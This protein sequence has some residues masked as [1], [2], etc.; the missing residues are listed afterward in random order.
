MKK[1]LVTGGA[2]YI[3]SHTV[4]SLKDKGFYPV[5]VDDLRS[6]SSF[7][8]EGLSTM[9]KDGYAFHCEDVCNV[10]SMTKIFREHRFDAVIHF[11]AY[12]SVGES[13]EEPLKYYQNN[14]QGLTNILRL[15]EEFGVPKFV[16]SSSC[17]VYG[18]PEDKQVYEHTPKRLPESPYGFT[19]WMG[20]Q[21]IEDVHRNVVPFQTLCLR[22][23]NP[24]GAHPSGM[25]G[26]L[27]K[28]IPNNLLPYITQT[29]TG[30]LPSLTVFGD[31]YPT[32]DGTC[33][34][35][36]IH[37]CDV[38][39]AHVKALLFSTS[40]PLSFFN[41]GTGYGTS[42]L[43]M[44]RLFERV[45]GKTL[46][47]SFG[48]RRKGDVVEIFANVTAA[49]SQLGWKAKRTIEEAIRDAWN[50]EQRRNKTHD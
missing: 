2:G 50:W 15:C 31:D 29:A 22:Y 26:E 34:R 11:A 39:D 49:Q 23:F 17:T 24:I 35:D 14:L 32:P 28:G 47:Y 41:I 5:I 20:E 6:S 30:V 36:Y 21:I 4:V 3:G 27:P 10:D 33:I 16:F 43:E 46:P 18:E 7:I 48:K 44:V 38:A 9:L 13:C 25:I 45:S 1:V 40:H 12:K 42:V 37:V 8:L 19:K